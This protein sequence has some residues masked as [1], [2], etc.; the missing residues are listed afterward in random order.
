[1][2]QCVL[3]T[4]GSH[5][6]AMLLYTEELKDWTSVQEESAPARIGFLTSYG[7]KSVFLPRSGHGPSVGSITDTGNLGIPGL[8]VFQINEDDLKMPS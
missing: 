3:G 8:W 5:T 6:F 1:M 7:F 2:F 4:D